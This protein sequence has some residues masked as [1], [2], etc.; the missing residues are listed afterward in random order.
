MP[1]GRL[2]VNQKWGFHGAANSISIQCMVMMANYAII[3]TVL[4]GM[5]SLYQSAFGMD[6]VIKAIQSST[7]AFQHSITFPANAI[8]ILAGVGLKS[9]ASM[10]VLVQDFNSVEA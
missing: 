8:K 1:L 7:K 6:H 3:R 2:E 10:A 5:A 4:I 9:G